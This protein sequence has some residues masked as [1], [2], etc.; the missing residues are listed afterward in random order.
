MSATV[1]VLGIVGKR[2]GGPVAEQH[3][4]KGRF[5]FLLAPGN[6]LPSAYLDQASL[7]GGHCISGEVTVYT[8]ED[9]YDDVRC[10][11]RARLGL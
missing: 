10:Y 11:I 4:T 2:P 3:T 9:V 7:R 8:N 6:Y 1:T 5:S